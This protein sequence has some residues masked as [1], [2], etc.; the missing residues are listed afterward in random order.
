MWGYIYTIQ[1]NCLCS[2][3]S[4]RFLGFFP[5]EVRDMNGYFVMHGKR[6]RPP[7]G[8]RI[9]GTQQSLLFAPLNLK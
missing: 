7:L 6:A 2:F 1:K 8:V 4:S 3:W 9:V 5:R